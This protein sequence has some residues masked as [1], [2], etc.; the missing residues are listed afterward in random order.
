MAA[1][2][3]A[4]EQLKIHIIDSGKGI[5]PEEM[6]NVFEKFGKVART[7]SQNQDGIGMGLNVCQR[8]IKQSGGEVHVV[9]DGAD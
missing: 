3:Y 6:A 5:A 7:V 4:T 9:S 1:Y 2:D 8:I